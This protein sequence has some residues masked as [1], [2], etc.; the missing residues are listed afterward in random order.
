MTEFEGVPSLGGTFC[1]P[2]QWQGWDK[3]QAISWSLEVV[4]YSEVFRR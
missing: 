4:A 1:N 3:S 2:Y